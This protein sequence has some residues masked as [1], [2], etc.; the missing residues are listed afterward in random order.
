[1]SNELYLTDQ[2]SLKDQNQSL[3][4]SAGEGAK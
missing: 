2:A 3:W 4:E 1:M